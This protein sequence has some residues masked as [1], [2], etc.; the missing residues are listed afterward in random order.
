MRGP[1]PAGPEVVPVQILAEDLHL[2][3]C[4]EATGR[5]RVPGAY[6]DLGLGG[7]L[8]LDLALRGRLALVDGH[9]AVVDRTPVGDRLIDH[10]L[11]VVAAGKPHGPEH[12]V[13][14]LARGA[15]AA[16][17]QRLVDA[18]VLAADDHRVLGVLPVHHTHQVDD[19]IEQPL[20]D[21]LGEAVVL[22]RPP[23]PHTAAV[24]SLALAVG[25]DG[26]LF[27]RADRRAVRHRMEEIA[28]GEWVGAAVRHSVAAIEA[29]LGVGMVAEP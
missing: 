29:A 17:R 20:L 8:L 13:D 1:A 25:L 6:L 9:V 18:G 27:P 22:G 2:L 28:R 24:V 16:V 7:A 11:T 5:P 23:S 19:R 15:R 10:A 12:W 3:A 21:R 26:H 14:V 4:D